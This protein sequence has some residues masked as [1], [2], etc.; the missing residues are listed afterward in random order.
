MSAI[1]DERQRRI[2]DWL[3]EKTPDLAGMYQVAVRQLNEQP[4]AGQERTRVSYICHSMREV[5]N[6]VPDVAGSSAIPRMKPPTGGQVQ[7]LPDL[8]TRHPDLSL[9]SQSD[10]V[11]I[12][13]EVAAVFDKLIKTAVHE[14]R[15]SR[16]VVASVLTDDGNA[17]A[18][19]VERWID[20]RGFFVRWTHLS[21][22]ADAPA[23]LPDD[24]EIR[25]H[26]AVFDEL[27]DGVITAFFTL[28]RQVDDLLAEFN[29]EVEED[30]GA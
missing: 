16:D 25:R 7:R 13:R 20:S 30:A 23:E 2:A 26:V 14:K 17:Q 24:D 12:P 5:M 4:A 9:E 6:R 19:A 22:Q 1:F 27:F 3:T 29:A 28:R 15:R 18:H 8:L 10:S 21:D 11:I